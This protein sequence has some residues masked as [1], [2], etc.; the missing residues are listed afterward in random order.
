VW[1]FSFDRQGRLWAGD[2]GQDLWEMVELVE[3]GGNYGWSVQEGTHVFDAN[4]AKGPT[5]I[6]KPIIERPHSESR[7]VTWGHLYEAQD[8]ADLKDAYIYGDYDTGKIWAFRYRDGRVVDHRQLADTQYRIVEFAKDRSGRVMVVDFISGTLMKLVPAPAPTGNEPRFPTRLSETGLFAS[9][10]DHRPAPGLIPYDVNAPLWSDGALKERFIALPGDSRIEFDAVKFPTPP[11]GWRFPHNTVLVKT[12]S[13]EM[14]Q[15]DPASRRR[16]ETRLLHHKRMPGNDDEYG[17]QVWLGY[18]Y[19]WNAEQTDAVLLDAAGEDR[20]FTIQDAAAPGGTR[21][22]T[23]HFPSRSECALC[24]TMA[25]KYALG[26]NTLQM[27]RDFDY[28][29][30]HPTNQLETLSRWGVFTEPL[31]K[32]ASEL[33]R[34]APGARLSARQLLALPSA[35]GRGTG[36]LFLTGRRAAGEDRDD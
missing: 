12:F 8:V 21:Q 36:R 3:K 11:P 4:R 27:N 24:H 9:T 14:K 2:V 28:G 31:P 22:Q 18:T 25:A 29:D 15:G 30:G 32:P 35:M 6:L 34:L 19:V 23:W 16:L 17:A 5:P 7:S 20:T 26:V 10:A 33:P 13:L 1:K